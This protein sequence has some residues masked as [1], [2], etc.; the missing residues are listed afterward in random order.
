MRVYISLAKEEAPLCLSH[1]I[2]YPLCFIFFLYYFGK[3]TNV[4]RIYHVTY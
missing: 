4:G 3:M 2:H 1:A